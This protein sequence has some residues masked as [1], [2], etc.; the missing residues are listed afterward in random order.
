[1]ELEIWGRG[2]DAMVRG[3]AG[4]SGR[5]CYAREAARSRPSKRAEVQ[6]AIRAGEPCIHCGAHAA[7]PQSGGLRLQLPILDAYAHVFAVCEAFLCET[8]SVAPFTQK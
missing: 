7:L 6:Q 3:H 8:C 4:E 5:L 2:E 1:M